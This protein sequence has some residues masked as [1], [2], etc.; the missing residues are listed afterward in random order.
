MLYIVNK[1]LSGMWC[2]N[3]FKIPVLFVI[4]LLERDIV[5]LV[6]AVSRNSKW[7]SNK[8][9]AWKGRLVEQQTVFKQLPRHKK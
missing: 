7:H 4:G 6:V 2:F 1:M 5:G 9:A 8:E 3:L